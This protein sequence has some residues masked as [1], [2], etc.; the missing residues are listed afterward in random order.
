MRTEKTGQ[1]PAKFV[2]A[3]KPCGLNLQSQMARPLL[4]KN[5]I[6]FEIKTVSTTNLGSGYIK[7]KR[8]GSVEVCPIPFIFLLS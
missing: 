8:R 4:F 2:E 3:I 7:R 6:G 1:G 5:E